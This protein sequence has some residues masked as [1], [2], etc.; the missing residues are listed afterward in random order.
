VAFDHK[1]DAKFGVNALAFRIVASFI[2]SGLAIVSVYST[3]GDTEYIGLFYLA[4]ATMG[5][6]DKVRGPVCVCVC[7]VECG[8]IPFLYSYVLHT[9]THNTP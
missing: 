1:Y 7:V 5:A 3:I 4:C 6:M 8:M 2:L 9:H